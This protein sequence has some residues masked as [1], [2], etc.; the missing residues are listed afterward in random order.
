MERKGIGRTSV[1]EYRGIDFDVSH[2]S[3]VFLG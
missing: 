3:N 1:L 2:S